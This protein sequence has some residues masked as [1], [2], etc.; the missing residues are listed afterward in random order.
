MTNSEKQIKDLEAQL[1][2]A[3]KEIRRLERI[4]SAPGMLTDLPARATRAVLHV[5]KYPDCFWHDNGWTV[6][7]SLTTRASNIRLA[8]MRRQH[9]KLKARLA[10]LEARK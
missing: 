4:L 5:L 6:L 3:N 8:F 7:S 10:E 2:L 1:A 9:L